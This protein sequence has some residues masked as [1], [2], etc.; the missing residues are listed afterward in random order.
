[1][2]QFSA[3]HLAAVGALVLLSAV[4]V[5]LAR[6]REREWG[7]AAARSLATLI[8]AVYLAEHVTYLARDTWSVDENL[9]LH[10]TDAVTL[11]AVAALWRPRI[12]LLVEILYFWAF[13]A[14][15]QAVLTPGVGRPFPDVLYFTYFVIHGGV[16]MAAA[17]LVFGCRRFPRPRA[18]PRVYGITAA[19]A[20]VAAVAC[21][22]TGGNYLFLRDKP[23]RES[24][25]DLMGPWPWYIVGG[26]VLGLAMFVALAALAEVVRRREA[27]R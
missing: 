18:V 3:E 13:S 11:V 22:T 4:L 20:V 15:L 14:S 5:R 9:P 2:E 10:L 1:M 24:L 19:F 17:L 25:L 21:V 12:R 27:G 7:D 23:P 26:A 16:L 8:L 6:R